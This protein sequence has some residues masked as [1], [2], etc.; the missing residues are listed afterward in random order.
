MRIGTN[1]AAA[2]LINGIGLSTPTR[3][4][5]TKATNITIIAAT[6]SSIRIYPESVSFLPAINLVPIQRKIATSIIAMISKIRVIGSLKFTFCCCK[7][8]KFTF[9][10]IRMVI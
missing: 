10:S 3:A 1:L 2:S 8:N 4:P 7:A 9:E 6:A 5:M